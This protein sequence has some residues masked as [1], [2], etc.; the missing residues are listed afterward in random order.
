M[1]LFPRSLPAAAAFFVVGAAQAQIQGPSTGSTPYLVPSNPYVQ[2]HSIFTVDNTGANPD[3]TVGG[4]GMAGI[5]DGLGAFQT[6]TD[7]ADGTFTVLMNHELSGSLGAVRA[8]G[9]TGAF[10]S[11]WTINKHTLAVNAGSDLIQQVSVWNTG[12]SSYN[13]PATGVQMS[14]FCS[15][16]LPAV[17]AF[18]DSNTGFGT[19]NRIFMTGEEAG[20]VGR[21]FA[22]IAS[23]P[24]A[25]ISYQL[26]RLGRFS[27]ENAVAN[28]NSG[29]QTVVLGT[30]DSS[31]GQVYLYLGNKTNTGNDIER[32]GLTNGGLYGIVANSIAS[33][34]RTTGFDLVAGNKDVV[35][36]TLSPF[37]NVENKTGIQ[38]QS[39]SV[40]AGVTE[41]L[42]P[43]DVHWDPNNAG[44][45]YF[46]TT[47]SQNSSGG[48]SRL[49][50]LDF[51]DAMDFTIG[52]TLSMLIEGGSPGD[53][54][55]FDNMVVTLDGK[56]IIQEDPG[57]S[58][59]PAKI[60][61]YNI[62]GD[63]LTE[64][65]KTDPAR[66]SPAVSPFATNKES[67]GVIDITDLM[68]GSAL[69]SGEPDEKWYLV[70]VQAHYS[71]GLT[72]AQVDGGQ[73]LVL[74]Y[75]PEPATSFMLLGGV[76]FLL[77]RRRR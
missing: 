33:E 21:A 45:A 65:A 51:A 61:E 77:G 17:S 7:I 58:P 41:F 10:V 37:G 50:K 46:V 43:E 56:I 25:G 57:A 23:G 36:F 69:N 63:T 42:R 35:P 48:R 60:W 20:N 13:A 32:A 3:D 55:M 6:P 38:L 52:G 64:L 74:H 9:S 19:Q 8:H 4:Y 29:A 34:S 30:D 18:F 75:V 68:A 72:S 54:D 31:P 59:L 11:K 26:P 62:A 53:G 22:H 71:L 66:F 40:A 2:T 39:D 5:P 67:S 27:W 49:W 76:G 12:T 47:D 15:A 1:K 28:P 24:S 14:R 70:D 44:I 16:D 73:L